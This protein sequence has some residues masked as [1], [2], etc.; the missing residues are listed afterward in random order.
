MD[1]KIKN[2]WPD[3]VRLEMIEKSE[4]YQE[5]KIYQYGYYDGYQ[6]A[7]DRIPSPSLSENIAS[8]HDQ[9]HYKRGYDDGIV[10]GYAM[11]RQEHLYLESEEIKQ[12]RD[13]KESA[14][15]V[16]PDYQAIGKEIGVRLGD[17]VH[18]KII[19]HIQKLK[20]SIASNVDGWTRVENGL[21]PQTDKYYYWLYSESIDNYEQGD[22]DYDRKCFVDK[23]GDRLMYVSHWKLPTP[24]SEAGDKQTKL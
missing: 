1:K 6:K 23:V 7:L 4:F 15:S 3:E 2:N 9:D 21:P 24:P 5:P 10:D 20:S 11:A 22:Y 14:M 19:P 13:W 18:D 8:Q 16:M 17:S 12:L